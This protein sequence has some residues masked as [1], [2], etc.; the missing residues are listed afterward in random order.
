MS[1]FDDLYTFITV[2]QAGSFTKAAQQLGVSKSALSQTISQLEQRLN[3]RLMN[4]TTRSLA[5]TTAGE[6]VLADFAPMFASMQSSLRELGDFHDQAV[7]TIRINT[8]EVTAYTVLYPKLAPL[9]SQHPHLHIELQIE[10]VFVDIVEKG[11]DMG[12]RLGNAVQQNMIAVRICEPVQMALVASR[13]YMANH[14]NVTQIDDLSR[15]QLIGARLSAT[16][17]PAEWEFFKDNQTIIYHPKPH[18]A[19]NNHLRIQAVLDGLGISW[20][21]KMWVNEYLENGAMV[22]LLPDWAMCYEPFYLYYPNRKHHSKAFEMVVAAL[23]L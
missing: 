4:R 2:V 19:I 22:E 20:L 21:P 9:L 10:N 15:H 1:H 18:F 11:F 23:R 6:K 17:Q 5:P 14:Q 16:H 3:I 12:V 7:G 8:S 13:E